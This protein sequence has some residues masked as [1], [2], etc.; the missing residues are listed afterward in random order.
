[1]APQ[2]SAFPNSCFYAGRLVDAH[3]VRQ[4][5]WQLPALE[6]PRLLGAYACVDVR[7]GKEERQPDGGG[8]W[9]NE[10]EADV[11]RGLAAAASKAADGKVSIGVISGYRAQ[12]R[13]RRPLRRHGGLALGI[14]RCVRRGVRLKSPMHPYRPPSWNPHPRRPALFRAQVDLLEYRLGGIRG[15]R[16][17]TVDGFQVRQCSRSFI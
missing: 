3:N 15:V 13:P 7:H 9:F 16:V 17:K 10:A 5:G 12:V 1:M 4:P 11:V 14:V 2:I 6:A 8:S